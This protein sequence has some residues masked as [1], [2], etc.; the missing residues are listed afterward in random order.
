MLKKS[1]FLLLALGF[2]AVA[3]PEQPQKKMSILP[4]TI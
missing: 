1:I 4:I 2:S 3:A